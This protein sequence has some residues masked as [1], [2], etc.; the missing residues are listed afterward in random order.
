MHG[1][2]VVESAKQG[3]SSLNGGA[4]SSTQDEAAPTNYNGS[5]PVSDHSG[6]VLNYLRDDVNT[7][8]RPEVEARETNV[9]QEE[10]VYWKESEGL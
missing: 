7:E 8:K 9:P 10:G 6:T 2:K 5:N 3:G 1:T 4:Q